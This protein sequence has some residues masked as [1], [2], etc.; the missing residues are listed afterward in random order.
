MP[1]LM[2]CHRGKSLQRQLNH[3]N[4]PFRLH[5]GAILKVVATKR[6]VIAIVKNLTKSLAWCIVLSSSAF[7]DA[8]VFRGL[9]LKNKA[10][11]QLFTV[12]DDVIAILRLLLRGFKN[13]RNI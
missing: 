12:R 2:Y 7:S 5:G 11:S 4:Q 8:S 9:G 1:P 3:C 13:V 6:E 10:I